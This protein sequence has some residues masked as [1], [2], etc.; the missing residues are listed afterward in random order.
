GG[1]HLSHGRGTHAGSAFACRSGGDD[2]PRR[3]PA[4]RARHAL[5]RQRGGGGRGAPSRSE[6][7]VAMSIKLAAVS[8][9]NARPITH[10][11]PDRFEVTYAEPSVCA[12]TLAR[13]EADC[14]LIPVASYA[15]LEGLRVVPG[16]AIAARGAGETVL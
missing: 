12:A 1:A 13:G 9:L 4:G 7:R 5:Q 2:S 10:A 6:G 14:G 11:L 3:P 8:F 15:A 16:I